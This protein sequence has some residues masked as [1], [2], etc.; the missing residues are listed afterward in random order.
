[1]ESPA[2]VRKGTTLLAGIISF[3]SI[4]KTTHWRII[5]RPQT[6]RASLDIMATFKVAVLFVVCPFR[7][8]YDVM[9]QVKSHLQF[10]SENNRMRS[11]F[12]V[13]LR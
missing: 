12:P 13:S 6:Y 1:M 2:V 11:V 9:I 8:T 3:S 5:Y 7:T 10:L 4:I